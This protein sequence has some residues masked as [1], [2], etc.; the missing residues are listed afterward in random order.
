[1]TER[2]EAREALTVPLPLGDEAEHLVALAAKETAG[3]PEATAE[4]WQPSRRRWIDI[5]KQHDAR[6]TSRFRRDHAAEAEHRTDDER[7]S[8]S[9][10]RLPHIGAISRGGTDE[11]R[12]H[13]AIDELPGILALPVS[14][15]IVLAQAT[16]PVGRTHPAP[17]LCPRR[18]DLGCDRVVCQH[19]HRMAPLD[20]PLHGMELGCHIATRVDQREQVV[21][22]SHR[23]LPLARLR[24]PVPVPSRIPE[25]SSSMIRSVSA[26][27][28]RRSR[29]SSFHV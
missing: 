27:D 21:A 4:R 16:R 2:V 18:A 1:V 14:R 22:G 24:R 13:Q 3:W 5:R 11:H 6:H 10:D 9:S 20:E 26:R 12:V 28:S 8:A 17:E 29:R 15:R 23:V 7:R 19:R 25:T